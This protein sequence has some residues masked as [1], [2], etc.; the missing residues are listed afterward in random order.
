[1]TTVNSIVTSESIQQVNSISMVLLAMTDHYDLPESV[2]SMIME[3]NH[4]AETLKCSS[5]LNEHVHLLKI[6]S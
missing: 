4:C 2:D 5:V 1:M 3:L 6:T